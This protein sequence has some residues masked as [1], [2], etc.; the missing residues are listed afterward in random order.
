MNE[1]EITV[2][3]QANLAVEFLQHLATLELGYDEGNGR[4][5]TKLEEEVKDS[6]LTMLLCYFETDFSGKGKKDPE[7]KKLSKEEK[8]K[9][10]TTN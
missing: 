10:T 3:E 9:E 1:E 6:A 5:L 7:S 4:E 8:Q 2:A